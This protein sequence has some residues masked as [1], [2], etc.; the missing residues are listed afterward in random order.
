MPK[1]RMDRPW[2]TEKYPCRFNDLRKG[3][4]TRL[5]SLIWQ[6]SDDEHIG[7]PRG[8]PCCVRAPPFAPPW[9]MSAA[10]EPMRTVPRPSTRRV[11][12]RGGRKGSSRWTSPQ[13]PPRGPPRRT[14]PRGPPRVPPWRHW[15]EGFHNG[16]PPGWTCAPMGLGWLIA[17]DIGRQGSPVGAEG[18]LSPR[19]FQSGGGRLLRGGR[20]RAFRRRG[21]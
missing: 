14:S 12:T 11:R 16:S 18:G 2:R 8:P 10:T 5:P 17:A 6:G 9:P 4:C 20:R 13:G 1:H 19:W 7:S 15:N 3:S 21:R